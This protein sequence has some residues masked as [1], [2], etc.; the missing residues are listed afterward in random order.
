MSYTAYSGNRLQLARDAL[1]SSARSDHLLSIFGHVNLASIGLLFPIRKP[2]PSRRYVILTHG[3]EVW[4][5]LKLHRR[6]ALRNAAEIW[7]VSAYS[8]RQIEDLHGVRDGSLRVLHNCLDPYFDGDVPPGTPA[9][10]ASS[11]VL[12]VSRLAGSERY[13]GVDTAIAALA[14]IH[15]EHPTLRLKIV[16]AGDD[17]PRLETLAE[18][19]GIAPSGFS[20]RGVGRAAARPIPRLP[21]L[22]P[23]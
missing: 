17:L 15:E 4:T 14:R 5:P 9:E 23:S 16:G 6:L 11:F 13:K 20:W 18:R 22:H 1:V 12:C 3:V 8:A 10:R 2:E 7:S 21:F 19:L